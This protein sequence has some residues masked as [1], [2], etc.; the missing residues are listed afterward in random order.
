MKR[1]NPFHQLENL[2][3]KN[4]FIHAPTS[5]FMAVKNTKPTG[6]LNGHHDPY[7]SQN[8]IVAQNSPIKQKYFEY[9]EYK[10]QLKSHKSMP[11]PTEV[12]QDTNFIK[13][14]ANA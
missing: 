12:P 5:Q 13:P 11:S 9:F 6:L 1:N 8:L 4:N 3:T 7:P 10:L 14:K 2:N